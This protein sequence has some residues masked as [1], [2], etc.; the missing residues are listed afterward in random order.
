MLKGLSNPSEHDAHADIRE[1]VRAL[2]AQ[3]GSAYFQKIDEARGYPEEF[4]GALTK[5]GWPGP[6]LP[7]EGK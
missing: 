2:C 4:V 3:F 6:K 1:G 5:A 7:L